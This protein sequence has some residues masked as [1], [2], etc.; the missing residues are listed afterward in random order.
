MNIPQKIIVIKTYGRNQFYG[1]QESHG[2][3]FRSG[4]YRGSGGAL[5]RSVGA[6]KCDLRPI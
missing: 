4:R 2:A 3:V 1:V 5:D 6:V